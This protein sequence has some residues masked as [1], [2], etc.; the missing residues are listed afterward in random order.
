MKQLRSILPEPVA[1]MVSVPQRL[2]PSSEFPRNYNG[3]SNQHLWPQAAPKRY[4]VRKIYW[5][6][7]T[8]CVQLSQAYRLSG[9]KLAIMGE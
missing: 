5:Q 7:N 9:I 1:E 6:R 3:L 4:N 2:R 8:Q